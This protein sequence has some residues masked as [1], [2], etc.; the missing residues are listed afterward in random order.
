MF[1]VMQ[2][3]I[4]RLFGRRPA[5]RDPSDDPYAGVRHPRTRRPGGRSS[6]VA[7]E[8][9]DPDGIVQALGRYR[10]RAKQ[11]IKR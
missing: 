1:R 9:P 6:A 5:P 7:V 8:E 2:Q 3:M 10:R 4:A 11:K